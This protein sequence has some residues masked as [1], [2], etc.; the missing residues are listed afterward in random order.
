MTDPGKVIGFLDL[1]GLWD[2]SL[3]LVM[4]GAIAVALPGF[5]W[6]RRR[7]RTWLGQPL[8]L[9]AAGRI[10]RRLVLGSLTFGAGWGLAGFCPGPALVS[11][12]AGQPKAAVFVLAML[13][14]MAVYECLESHVFSR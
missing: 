9:P 12:A 1:A 14:G 6:A 2:P 11:V 10:D 7:G 13:A 3:A 8:T 4:G 5:A